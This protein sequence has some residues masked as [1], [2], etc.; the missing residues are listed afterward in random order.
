M[1]QYIWIFIRG[2]EDVACADGT[3]SLEI[4]VFGFCVINFALV[5]R[6]KKLRLLLRSFHL[7]IIKELKE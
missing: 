6:E 1:I 5:E 3:I 2:K 7:C 4:K